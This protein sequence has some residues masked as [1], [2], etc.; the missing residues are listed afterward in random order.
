MNSG[1]TESGRLWPATSLTRRFRFGLLLFGLAVWPAASLVALGT[2]A[3]GYAVVQLI[4]LEES[5]L[6]MNSY[7]GKFK[8]ASYD[9]DEQCSEDD[10]LCYAPIA[11]E[12]R[13][14]VRPENKELIGFLKDND[15]REMLVQYRIHRVEPMGLSSDF[16][17]TEAKAWAE[18]PAEDM[19]PEFGIEKSGRLRSFPVYGR[20]IRFDYRGTV[21]G[22]WEGLYLDARRRKVHPF[23]I[24]DQSMADYIIKAIQSRRQ[25]HFLVSQAYVVTIRESDH[26]I[27]AI[28]YVKAPR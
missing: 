23:S 10:Y 7:E 1:M 8:I 2:Y 3:E 21:V 4:R 14:S 22:T 5:G 13:F 17:V 11:V 25:Y 24:T 16:E 15:G 28:D 12:Q 18:N 6:F 26:D 20:V 9:K 19:N 27:Y